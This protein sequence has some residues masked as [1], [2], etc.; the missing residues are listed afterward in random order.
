MKQSLWKRADEVLVHIWN[1]L[2]CFTGTAFALT[3]F[4]WITHLHSD[5]AKIHIF[6][7]SVIACCLLYRW[8]YRNTRGS[9]AYYRANGIVV[10]YLAQ[11]I[12]TSIFFPTF[13]ILIYNIK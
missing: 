1:F 9:Q 4:G 7:L 2:G 3:L 5:L 6:E 8:T 13:S 12:I 10:G 11:C